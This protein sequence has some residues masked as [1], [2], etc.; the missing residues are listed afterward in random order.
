[1]HS[2]F[3]VTAVTSEAASHFQSI[4]MPLLHVTA[5]MKLRDNGPEVSFVWPALAP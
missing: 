4:E 1:M 5:P 2:C 3:D